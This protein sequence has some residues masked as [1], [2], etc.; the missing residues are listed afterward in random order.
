MS[1]SLPKL[2][3]NILAAWEDGRTGLDSEEVK[4]FRDWRWEKDGQEDN[5]LTSSGHL[6]HWLLGRRFGARLTDL[7]VDIN[8]ENNRTR[9][10]SSSKQRARAS[11]ESFLDGVGGIPWPTNRY[12]ATEEEVFRYPDIITDDHL[13]RYYDYCPKYQ[14]EVKGSY[15]VEVEEFEMSKAFS[16]MMER[17]NSRVGLQLDKEE[18]RL[19]WNI[20]RFEIAWNLG[21]DS[22]WC[23][24]FV[25]EDLAVFEFR[26]DLKYF[27]KYDQSNVTVEMTQPLWETIFADLD[28][29]DTASDPVVRLNF[30]HLS[31]IMPMLRALG[32]YKDVGLKSRDW[33]ARERLWK[34]STIGAF[35]SNLAVFMFQCNQTSADDSNRKEAEETSSIEEEDALGEDSTAEDSSSEE[36]SSESEEEDS[37]EEVSSREDSTIEDEREEDLGK[38]SWK[39]VVV[40][41]ERPLALDV[42]GG[43]TLCPLHTFLQAFGDLAKTDFNA[44]CLP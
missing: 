5:I 30:A 23:A 33:P 25:A 18:A 19:M 27:Y 1:T 37:S 20:C 43:V 35:A 7:G 11:A 26:E 32:V 12:N 10:S 2:R 28:D 15:K 3:D 34:T 22:P 39:V 36:E 4:A 8:L 9:V 24:A 38:P 44:T 40:H 42:C 21:E 6:E 31:T 14:D 41:Q 16:K 17:V 29:L 13:L